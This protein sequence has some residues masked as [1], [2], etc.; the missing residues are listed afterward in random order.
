MRAGVFL[1]ALAQDFAVTLLV[2]PVAG[3]AQRPMSRFAVERAAR[4]VTVALDDN[5]D[6]LWTLMGRISDPDGRTA[7]FAAY[8]RPAMCR[9]ASPS[10][11]SAVGAELAPKRFDVVHVMRSYMTPYAEPF[12]A[13][14]GERP[15][16]HATL[17]L[18]DD[19][20]LTLTRIAALAERAGALEDARSLADEAA[21]YRRFEPIWLPRFR[22]LIAANPAHAQRLAS[23]NPGRAVVTVANTVALPTNR[24]RVP[25]RPRRGRSV[26]NA[27]V[28]ATV[29]TARPG[30]PEASLCACAGFAA[31]SNRKRGSHMG[32]KRL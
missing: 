5:V 17:D 20:A 12:L 26:G 9:H 11:R 22:L 4:I 19:E 14:G 27:T 25:E 13:E 31:I 1:D 8:P 10:Y 24:M 32:S 18:D 16:P 2:V 21:R 30:L 23:D 6:P 28:F 3:G 15:M 7:A 29:T